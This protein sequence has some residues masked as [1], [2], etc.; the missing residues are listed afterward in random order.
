MEL[1]ALTDRDMEATIEIN[2]LKLFARHGVFEEERESGN[3]FELTVHLHYPIEKAMESDDVA[4]TLNYAEA[5]EII[6]REMAVA[7]KLLEHAV[8]RIRKALMERYPA[9]TGGFISLTK[10]NP[11]IPAD[12]R[13]VAVRIDW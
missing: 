9:I 6:R 4:D 1:M 10:L 5:V 8:G 3:F 11:P 7:S 12:I 13:G 2:G